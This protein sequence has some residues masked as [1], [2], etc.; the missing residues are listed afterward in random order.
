MLKILLFFL[1]EE[2]GVE[3]YHMQNYYYIALWGDDVLQD[4]S[5][6]WDLGIS[7]ED[8]ARRLPATH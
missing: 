6:E 5:V 3:R 7:G 1:S 8:L 4:T 2:K